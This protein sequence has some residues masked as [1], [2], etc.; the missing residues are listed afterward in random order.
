MIRLPG[1]KVRS[2]A[3]ASRTLITKLRI[4]TTVALNAV[5]IAKPPTVIFAPGRRSDL[6]C[7]VATIRD[8]GAARA[9]GSEA[10]RGHRNLRGAAARGIS[11]RERRL[12]RAWPSEWSHW[13]A[14]CKSDSKE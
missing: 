7:R 11:R 1:W 5:D 2:A 4:A 10:R 13:H 9:C 14:P 3:P 12:I 8:P 6:T